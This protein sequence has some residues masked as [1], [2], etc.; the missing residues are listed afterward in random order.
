MDSGGTLKQ[1]LCTFWLA[2]R[3]SQRANLVVVLAGDDFNSS[4]WMNQPE[5]SSW[6]L[7][8]C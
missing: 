4:Q 7:G 6:D 2:C 1:F 8:G 3:S 5:L